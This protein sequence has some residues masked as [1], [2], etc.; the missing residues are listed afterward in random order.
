[1]QSKAEQTLQVPS[2]IKKREGGVDAII[3][4]LL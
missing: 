2:K 4:V 3:G 1:M